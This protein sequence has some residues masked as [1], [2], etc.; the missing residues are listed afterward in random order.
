[1]VFGFLRRAPP[2]DPRAAC[3]LIQYI[4]RKAP[5]KAAAE[6]Y[7]FRPTTQTAHLRRQS[8]LREADAAYRIELLNVAFVAAMSTP[9][10]D[11]AEIAELLAA[12]A[13]IDCA[14]GAAAWLQFADVAEGDARDNGLQVAYSVTS[15]LAMLTTIDD[16]LL[17]RVVDERLQILQART[18]KREGLISTTLARGWTALAASRTLEVNLDVQTPLDL[19]FIAAAM[20]GAADCIAAADRYARHLL[21]LEFEEADRE[22]L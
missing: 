5:L 12:E 19:R 16:R 1:M 20:T 10:P 6:R 17:E 3:H 18:D 9:P 2:P 13:V 21:D 4:I 8:L 7:A 11:T 14:F 15:E 22:M